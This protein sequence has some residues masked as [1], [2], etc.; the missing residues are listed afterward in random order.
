MHE[1]VTPHLLGRRRLLSYGVAAGALAATGLAGCTT[2]G[3]ATNPPPVGSSTGVP[4]PTHV[5]FAAAAPDG[6]GE[7]GSADFYRHYPANP[8]VTV[9]EVPGDGKPISTMLSI[10]YPAWPAAP[11]NTALDELNTKLGSELQFTQVPGAEYVNKFQTVIAGDNLSAVMEIGKVAR[12]PELM[13]SKFIDLTPHLSGDAV[14]KYPN[15]ANIPQAAWKASVINNAIYGIPATRGMWQTGMMFQRD[16]LIKA[17]GLDANDA[18]NF[19]DFLKLCQELTDGRD[20][21]ALAA[22]PIAHIRMMLRIPNTWRLDGGKL[23][24]AYEV[25]EQEEALNALLK[26]GS[27][28]VV[29]PDW[30]TLTG[31]QPRQLFTD[32]KVLIANGTY[33]GWPRYHLQHTGNTPFDFDGLPIPGFDGGDGVLHLAAP[34]WAIAGIAKGNEARVETLLKVWNYLAAPFGSAEQ[35][36]VLY[37]RQGVDYTLQGSDPV[38]TEQGKKNAM[39]LTTIVCAPQAAYYPNNPDVAEK[40]FAHMKKVAPIAIDNPVRYAYSDTQSAKSTALSRAADDMFTEIVLGRRKISEWAGA[41]DT[42]RKNGGDQ[43]RGE[44]EEAVANGG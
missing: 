22:M 17:K 19:E 39:L 9:P 15:L 41:V 35:P 40:C 37:G 44:L 5:P 12:L 8:P 28:K 30:F 13:R 32:G 6:K 42:W 31:D 36:T 43:M 4:L 16:D 11:A 33:Q 20:V 10:F 18:T 7:K 26:L 27:A 29:R 14:K 3:K 1:A 24:N 2:G 34:T 25:P 21:F 38:Q 23:V